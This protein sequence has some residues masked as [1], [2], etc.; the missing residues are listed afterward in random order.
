[1][2]QLQEVSLFMESHA[3]MEENFNGKAG[4]NDGHT[5]VT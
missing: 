5:L 3:F 2:K 1:L 4:I